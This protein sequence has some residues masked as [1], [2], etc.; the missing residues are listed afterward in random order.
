VSVPVRF[1]RCATTNEALRANLDLPLIPVSFTQYDRSIEPTKT[2]HGII[3]KPMSL[4]EF[5]S[6]GFGLW[7]NE[8]SQPVAA[9]KDGRAKGRKLI[10]KEGREEREPRPEVSEA[11]TEDRDFELMA[12]SLIEERKILLK[13]LQK[14]QTENEDLRNEN[15]YRHLMVR[16][17]KKQSKRLEKRN[18]KV[19]D[20]LYGTDMFGLDG[21]DKICLPMNTAV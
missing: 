20:I 11:I 17:M 9:K 4:Q 21:L 3:T 16:K 6:S 8:I 12:A 18:E 13:K 15:T 2:L 5:I 7:T 14:L 10:R 1:I 19:S